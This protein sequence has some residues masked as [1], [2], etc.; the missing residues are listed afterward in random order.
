MQELLD[1]QASRDSVN[2]KN[3][4]LTDS[5]Q[6]KNKVA[7]TKSTAD[8]DNDMSLGLNS[9]SS[10]KIEPDSDKPKKIVPTIPVPLKAEAFSTHDLKC[11]SVVVGSFVNNKSASFWCKVLKKEHYDARIIE[12]EQ[13]MYRVI[14]L[15]TDDLKEATASVRKIVGRFPGAWLLVSK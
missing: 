7:V 1:E 11:Y 4:A 2:R 14:I 6:R 5:I 8:A 3:Q 12:N 15:T 10:K 9:K 13:G